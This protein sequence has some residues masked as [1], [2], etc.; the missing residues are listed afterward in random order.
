MI[1]YQRAK[2]KIVTKELIVDD[3]LE[4]AQNFLILNVTELWI[5]LGMQK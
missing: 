2:I 4:T 5:Q 3:K 1:Y